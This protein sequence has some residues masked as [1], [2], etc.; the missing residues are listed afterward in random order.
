MRPLGLLRAPY[1][2]RL[3]AGTL[4]GRLPTAMAALAIPLV[5]RRSGISY[6]LV[7]LAVGTFAVA[8]AVGGPLL[9]RL[10]DRI[11]Q[12]RVLATASVAAAGGFAVMA[13]APSAIA[14]VLPGAVLAGAATPPLEP[15]L[16]VLWPHLVAP[17]DLESAYAMDSA[18]QEL[19]FVGGPLVVAACVA[20]GSPVVALWVAALLGLAGV[21]VVA[22][23]PP[24]RAWR[25]QARP[26]DWLGPLRVGGLAT[27]L[28]SLVG[29]GVALGMLNVLVVSYAERHHLPGG[30][31]TLLALNAA[32]AL[33]GALAY[34]A[35]RWTASP[36]RRLL[37]LLA[38]LAG[39]YAL[40]CTL[41]PPPAMAV[42]VMLAGFF[43]AP[44]LTVTF[45]LVGELAP[46]GTVTEAFAWLVTLFTCGTAAGS[47]ITG[48][49]LQYVDAAWAASCGALGVTACAL[50]QFIGRH[51]LTPLGRPEADQPAEAPG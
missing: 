41:P 18:A 14:V 51:Q 28:A 39:G 24:A 21:L 42:V 32:G 15:C 11:G 49:L 44:V 17:G 7:G 26:A 12:V 5:L 37:L 10:V 23:A 1:V 27:L 47:A 40:V 19:I 35:V 34:G 20:T 3:M 22:T 48:A 43:L 25:A 9:G 29:V 4:V 45:V 30:A 16:R 2:A 50:V 33:A 46:P 36:P 31:A 13:L 8:A 6:G 38:G